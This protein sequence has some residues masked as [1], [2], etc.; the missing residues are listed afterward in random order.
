MLIVV[1]AFALYPFGASPE[2]SRLVLDVAFSPFLHPHDTA[3]P[4]TKDVEAFALQET[5][6]RPAVAEMQAD[7]D[8][9][10]DPMIQQEAGSSTGLLEI[11]EKMLKDNVELSVSELMRLPLPGQLILL[12]H[13]ESKWNRDPAIFTGWE[14]VDLSS[15]G[16][17]EA[18]EA[19]EILLLESERIDVVYTSGLRR[20]IRT[21]EICIDTLEASGRG[22]PPIRTRWRLNERHYGALQG[23]NKKEAKEIYE[24]QTELRAWRASFDGRPPAMQPDHPHY[25]RTQDRFDD[26][27]SMA[28]DDTGWDYK[29]D[30]DDSTG[31]PIDYT[32]SISEPMV[33]EDIPLTESLA[34]TRAR[35]KTL[36]TE[37][38][39][40]Q[41][42]SGKT[43]LLVGHKNNMKALISVIQPE[44]C[45]SNLAALD[46][47]NALPIVYSFDR[48]GIPV[49]S[50]EDHC[51]V[52]PIKAHYL[53]EE[54][55]VFFDD[56]EED[57]GDGSA[58][59]LKASRTFSASRDRQ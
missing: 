52:E 26:L 1:S 58:R 31:R 42:N 3:R 14:N 46:V 43:M 56:D 18:A 16:E 39:W 23:T 51:Y 22:R 10:H 4:R 30:V 12:R 54:C 49:K 24:N 20:S 2:P 36:W 50:L 44:L 57:V 5:A 37:E 17:S 13:G 32:A 11:W 45:N 47:P 9:Y 15:Q 40:P 41:L 33:M 25:S 35:V 55:L 53:G 28:R 8:P 7:W 38:L 27:V 21:A 19:A 6:E 59:R 29:T 34:D 48:E